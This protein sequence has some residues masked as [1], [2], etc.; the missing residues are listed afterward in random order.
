MALLSHWIDFFWTGSGPVLEK[1]DLGTV[2][3]NSLS[4]LS[5][6]SHY[7]LGVRVS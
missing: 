2:G 7:L 1:F 3:V 5:S 6:R 4:Q